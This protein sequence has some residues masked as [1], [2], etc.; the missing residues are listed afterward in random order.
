MTNDTD[1][2]ALIGSRICHDLVNPLSAIS[3]GVELLELS[4]AAQTPEMALI[5]DSV[6]AAMARVKLFRL[7]FGPS[8]CAQTISRS[9]V[10]TLLSD[11][12]KSGRLSFDWQIDR[13]VNRSEVR[14][15]ILAALCIETATPLGAEVKFRQTSTGFDIHGKGRKIAIDPALW[16]FEGKGLSAAQVQFALLPRVAQNLNRTVTY[17]ATD[18]ELTVAV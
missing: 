9:E 4:G 3:N 8:D 11:V 18:T 1:I 5:A 7:A 15:L 12:S 13:D 2:A 17:T 16:S 10:I 6:A 14:L